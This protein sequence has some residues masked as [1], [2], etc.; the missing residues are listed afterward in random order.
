MTQYDK[1]VSSMRCPTLADLPKPPED[2]K[3][4]PWTEET[5]QFPDCKDGKSCP[6]ISIVTPSLNQGEF[7][8]ETIRSVLLQG[9]PIL[10][11][12]I[13]DG[14]S[15]DESVNIIRKYEPWIHYWV[16][17]PDEG[18]TDAINK[19]LKKATG[20]IVAYLNSDDVYCPG[21]LYCV[22]EYF[23][24]YPDI[25]MM[26]GDIIHIDRYGQ[27]LS[28]VHAGQLNKI[29]YIKCRFYIPQPTVF[30]RSYL[31]NT[32]GLF[33]PRF[34]L[35]MDM[36]YWIR[37]LFH[38]TIG[39]NPQILAKARIYNEAKSSCHRSDYLKEHLMILDLIFF[40]DKYC[41][42]CH[43]DILY[44]HD[45]KRDFFGSVYFLGGCVYLRKRLFSAAILNIH[46]GC[47]YNSR[48]I[49]DDYLYR[50]IIVAIL[51]FR[52]SDKLTQKLNILIR[53]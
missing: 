16:S 24:K 17:E 22:V 19:G 45:N 49:L 15:T 42:N 14:G 9:Y 11:Y 44:I 47:R 33:D 34:H 5:N 2:K 41:N 7:I 35:A 21:T 13:I 27:L 25:S 28:K 51:G 18:Q 32:L 8:E 39:Y 37:I 31:L 10:E 20:D 30:F 4:W 53:E 1:Q 6:K 26:Y 52:L 48:L 40:N 50:S 12:C 46:K 36:E 3:G 29:Q 23:N 43:N 38:Y